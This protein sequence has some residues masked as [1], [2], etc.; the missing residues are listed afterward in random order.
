M[1]KFIST[2]VLCL[3]ILGMVQIGLSAP[4]E[5]RLYVV[6]KVIGDAPVMDGE[7][8]EEEWAG[9]E[10]TTGF[11]GLNN[12]DSNGANQGE[13]IDLNY[14]WRALWDDDY[15]YILFEAEMFDLPINGIVGDEIVY[16]VEQDDDTF[17]YAIGLGTDMEIFLEP[18][19]QEGDGFNSNPPDFT[20]PGG[21]GINDGYHLVWFP[22]ENDE[23]FTPINE[24]VRNRDNVTGPPF[25]STSGGYNST[26]LG[27][28]WDPTFDPAVAEAEG[29][30]PLIAGAL[31]QHTGNERASGEVYANPTL[32]FAFPFSQ[33]N[34]TW[35]V[36]EQ[37]NDGET[38]LTVAQDADGNYVNPGD[39]WLINVAGYTDAYTAEGGLTLVTWN[40]VIGG[41]FASYPR[42][43][44][45][46]AAGG[47][48]VQ[49]WMLMD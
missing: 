38:N 12:Q 2:L 5:S 17:S 20:D 4:H 26:Y 32:E 44:L 10:W 15:L 28:T 8:T 11:F 39:E 24:G 16:P 29:A 13:P 47:T 14:R 6:N 42:G 25:F 36:P 7:Y 30:E 9:S 43:I 23:D 19:W 49:N 34:P 37:G 22:L 46:F 45:Q 1:K 21:D 48:D 33:F 31:L 3:F 35:G 27:G 40:N 18:D 41:P